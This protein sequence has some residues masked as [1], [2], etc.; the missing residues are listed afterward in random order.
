MLNCPGCGEE[1]PA[2]FR[3]CGYCG[4]ALTTAAPSLPAREV[5]KTVTIVFSDLKGSTALGEVL[6]PEALHEVKERYFGAMAAE[7]TRHGGKIEKY[8]GDAIMA[9]FGLPRAHEDDALR[10]VRA[11]MG[12]QAALR[13]VNEDLT[14]RY[15][16]AL[17]NRTGVNTGEVVASDDPTA[18]QKLATGDAVNVAARLEQAAPEN[19][20]YLGDVTYRLVRDAV[21]VESVEPLELKGK[22]QRVPAYRL[23]AAP[24]LDGLVRR[25]DRPLVGRDA[26][27]ATLA[28]LYGQVSRER[29]ARM[30]TLIGDAGFGKSRLVHEVVDRIAVGARVLTGRCLPYGDGITFWPLLMM[31]REAADIRDADSPE[32][33]QDKLLAAVGDAEVA[34]RLASAAG[35]SS[36]SFPLAELNWAARKFFEGWSASAPLVAFIDDIHWAEPAFLDLLEHVQL[37]ALDAPILLLT[38][39]RHDLIE[40]RAAWGT[41]PGSVR[42]VL[43]PLSDDASARVVA[44]LLGS[45]GLSAEVTT[46]IVQ[47]AEGNPL[48]AEQMLSMLI[49][50]GALRVHDGHWVRADETAEIAVPPTIHALLEAR[51]DGLGRAER[52]AVE[53]AS[54]IG[55]EF[56]QSAVESLSPQSVRTELPAHLG[57]L[58]RKRFIRPAQSSGAE[59]T[60]RFHH[61]LV[62]ETVYNGLLKRARANLHLE[63]VRWADRAN[64]D[65]DRALEFEEILGYHLEQA[66]RY[67]RELGPLDTQGQATGSDAARRLSAA[68]RRAAA[69]GDMH[70]AANLYR[71]AVAVLDNNDPQRW[72]LLPDLAE[73]LIG[74][75][76]FA[77]AH[78]ALDEASGAADRSG[79]ARLKASSQLLGMFVRLYSGEQQDDW[80]EETLRVCHEL[81]PMLEREKAHNEVATAWRLVVLVHG[82]AGRFTQASEGVAH[83]IAHARLAG[84]E[85]L[86]ARNGLMLAINAL[87]GPMPVA[88]AIVDCEQLLAAGLSDRQVECNVMCALAQLKAMNGELDAARLLY[89]RSRALLRDLGQGV[90]AASTGIDLARVE[91]HGGDLALAQREVQADCDFLA[92]KGETYFL[93]TM[94]ALLARI[95]RDQGRDD[96]ALA[97]S[98]TAEEATASDDMESQALWRMVRAPI[99]ARAGELLLAEELARNAVE[100]VRRTESPML[101]A[102][103]LAELAAVLAIAERHDEAHCL[104]AEALALYESKGNR[105]M[106]RRCIAPDTQAAC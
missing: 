30:V 91:L 82:I 77:G 29:T 72:Q 58:T 105:V 18:D 23:V 76:D 51:L 97:L 89:R 8:I 53:P 59:L 2:K 75:G 63:F 65:S 102:D 12:M 20:I 104:R 3:L 40:E 52:A 67:L 6:D 31:V 46:R 99:L 13:R 80:S 9:V 71:R 28:E 66:H 37:T 74:V 38:T 90:Y 83:S 14:S 26:E 68:G 42:L 34:Q 64:A 94:A 4:T 100:L 49:D 103:A 85:R 33:A 54:V 79:N 45:A 48:Y 106:A 73:T 1:N 44:N 78:G 43:K 92:A 25:H 98:R 69:R 39:A 15:G 35:L 101:Q 24:G 81:I 84:N 47:A 27:L 55:L 50:S 60:Y 36:A 87:N 11:A 22:A 41:Q 10:A 62:R 61:H 88:Q 17:A 95:A 57:T 93:S 32:I 16:V 5:R 86:V 21:E 19:Q 96:E 56:P 70:A 7:I